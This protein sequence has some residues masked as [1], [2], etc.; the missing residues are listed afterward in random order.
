LYLS[1]GWSSRQLTSHDADEYDRHDRCK[2]RTDGQPAA[3]SSE[4]Q[5]AG[6]DESLAT[7]NGLERH[8]H[9]SRRVVSPTW[10]FFETSLNDEP[11]REGYT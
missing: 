1:G 10:I 3:V 4:Q 8:A 2:S 6:Q 11:Q 7:L 5:V 9:L